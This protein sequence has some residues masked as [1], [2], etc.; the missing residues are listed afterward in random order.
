MTGGRVVVLGGI[1][2]NFAAGMS[3]GIA[4]VLDEQGECAST[5]NLQM[6]GLE[7]LEDAAEIDGLRRMIESHLHHTSSE[8]A[9]QVLA[10]WAA[11]VP[12]VV[13]VI[14]KDYKRMLAAI[15]RAHEQG[16]AGEEAIMVAFTENAGDLARIGGN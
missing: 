13:K 16:L 14:P 3:G 1:G 2:R 7:K 12:R 5:V 4:Y 10:D 9:K 8:R 6:V 15:E 11:T